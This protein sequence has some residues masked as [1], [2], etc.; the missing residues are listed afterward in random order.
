VDKL[1]KE[2]VAFNGLLP[3]LVNLLRSWNPGTLSRETAYRD[4]L[5]EFLRNA[6]PKDCRVEREY[7]HGGTTADVFISWKGLLLNGEL[8]V[9]MK[10][11][12]K[13]KS[14]F[15][16]LIGQLEEL[17]PGKQRILLVLVGQTDEGLLGRIKSRYEKFTC[18]LP[19]GE[20]MAIVVKDI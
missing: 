20:A 7:R 11:N 17:K 9:E 14:D 19:D 16:R 15:D 12:L 8:F 3:C 6:F 4:S 5:V 1:T 10:R 2:D 18:D 13:K